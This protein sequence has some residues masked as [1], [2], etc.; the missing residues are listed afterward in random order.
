MKNSKWSQKGLKTDDVV[1]NGAYWT[2]KKS[3]VETS[4]KKWNAFV[5]DEFSS[6]TMKLWKRL[7]I[8]YTKWSSFCR[9]PLNFLAHAI[10]V[11]WWY[12]AK[13]QPFQSSFVLLFNFRVIRRKKFI[14]CM[15]NSKWSYKGLKFEDVALTGAYWMHKKPGVEIS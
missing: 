7:S 8:L 4:L 11:K 15:K 3:E 10:W 13:F 6:E 9:D 2:H 14:K 5:T 1:S 12:H